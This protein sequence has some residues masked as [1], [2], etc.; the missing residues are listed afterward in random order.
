M[1]RYAS[2]EYFT[3]FL[4]ISL[5]QLE[6]RIKFRNVGDPQDTVREVLAP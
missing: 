6:S 5:T 1:W 3:E 4:V 2:F